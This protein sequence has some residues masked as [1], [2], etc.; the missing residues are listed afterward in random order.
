MDARGVCSR[1]RYSK[2]GNLSGPW[3]TC[4]EEYNVFASRWL[5]IFSYEATRRAFASFQLVG[6]VGEAVD[7]SLQNGQFEI[8]HAALR[9]ANATGHHR[10]RNRWIGI[11]TAAGE[12]V[13]G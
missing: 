8:T 7:H 4:F 5:P 11:P 12:A 2:M 10:P 13:R 9:A 1:V 3:H 6:Q